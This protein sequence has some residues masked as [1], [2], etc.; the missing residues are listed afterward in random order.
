MTQALYHLAC[1]FEWQK[2]LREEVE[3]VVR[4]NGWSKAAMGKMRKIDSFLREQQRYTGLGVRECLYTDSEEGGGTWLTLHMQ[5]RCRAMRS[6]HS[7]SPMV[8]MFPRELSLHVLSMI[9]TTMRRTMPIPTPLTHGTR[10]SQSLFRRHSDQFTS[11]ASLPC[12]M[13]TGRV[14]SINL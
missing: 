3:E 5:L 10:Y 14:Q 2:E 12:A 11:G 7:R 9:R 13:K 1:N 8:Y 4:A 6:S